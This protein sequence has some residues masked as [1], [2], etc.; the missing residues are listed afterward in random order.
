MMILRLLRRTAPAGALILASGAS[1]LAGPLISNTLITPLLPGQ[2][3]HLSFIMP[4]EFA[5]DQQVWVVYELVALSAVDDDSGEVGLE[6]AFEGVKTPLKALYVN[7]RA[8]DMESSPEKVKGLIG[9]EMYAAYESVNPRGARVL[10]GHVVSYLAAPGKSDVPLLVS[11]ERAQGM[12]PL[13]LRVTV[14]Q[15]QL[16]L[17]FQQKPKDTVAYKVGYV[18]GLALFG[19]LLWRLVR[20]LTGR[21]T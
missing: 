16:P 14:G 4:P 13:A 6:Q 5:A 8:D 9:T 10:G 1:A 7:V 17:E 11:V 19:W 2:N 15:G 3:S 12:Q 18:L 21:R 20:R